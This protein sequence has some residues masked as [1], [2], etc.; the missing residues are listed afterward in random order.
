M[1]YIHTTALIRRE[2]FPGFDEKIKKFQDWDLWLTMLEQGHEGIWLPE[3]LFKV[4]TQKD[5]LSSWLPKFFYR[6]PWKKLGIRIK[7][8]EKY[9]K[10]REIIKKKHQLD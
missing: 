10:A 8:I 1:P 9:E 5:G 4:Y 2:H 6:I 7:A 3:V